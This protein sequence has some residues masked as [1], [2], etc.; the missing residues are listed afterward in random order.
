[1]KAARYYG[2][3]DIRVEQIAEPELRPG[4]VKIAPAF[5]GICGSDLHL[6]HN[7]PLGLPTADTPHPLSGETL[8]VV[9]GHEFSGVVE[10]IGEGVEE[11]RV[12]QRLVR[13]PE[14]GIGRPL[15]PQERPQR[16]A[17]LFRERGDR[18]P[19]RRGLQV[20]DHLR[21]DTGGA[22]QAERVARC[23]AGGVVIDCDVHLLRSHVQ[24]RGAASGPQISGCP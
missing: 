6:Y 8:P 4:T 5:N 14:L 21:L 19:G 10:A 11:L 2:K 1:M 15:L 22:D 9:L 16:D 17:A 13:E 23:P 3:E 12:G 24:V 18:L 7:G 20:L